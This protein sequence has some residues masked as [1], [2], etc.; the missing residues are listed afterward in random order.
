MDMTSPEDEAPAPATY[1]L[2]GA[3]RSELGMGIGRIIGLIFA[4]LLA[5]ISVGIIFTGALLA[6]VHESRGADGFLSSG[7]EQL[8]T[9]TAAL[10]SARGDINVGGIGWFADHLGTIRITATSTSGKPV[11]IGVARRT[12]VDSWLG[13]TG[14]DQ[15]DDLQFE[16]FQATIKRTPG[17]VAALR[18]PGKQTFWTAKSAGTATQTLNWKVTSGDWAVV[19]ANADGSPEVAVEAR[20][21]AKL[22]W[23]GPLSLGII[24][25][26]VVLFLMSVVITIL[27]LRDRGRREFVAQPPSVG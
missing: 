5:L 23:L 18:A 4:G 7:T 20:F 1:T 17:T 6:W 2:A 10:T 19:V 14:I 16:P 21:G 9:P 12:E 22:S 13:A 26:G 27:L 25:A 8:S 3:G 11:F 15:I 24:I